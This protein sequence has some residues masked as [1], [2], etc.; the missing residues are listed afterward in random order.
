MPKVPLRQ[1]RLCLWTLARR[2]RLG[3]EDSFQQLCGGGVWARVVAVRCGGNILSD[4]V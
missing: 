4:G 3:T 1:E 2:G